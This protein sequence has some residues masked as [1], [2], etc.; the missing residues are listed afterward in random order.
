[1]QQPARGWPAVLTVG[2][3]LSLMASPAH[4]DGW[5]GLLRVMAAA[6][7]A[8][9]AL[10]A[11]ALGVVIEAEAY[12]RL[13]R[14]AVGHPWRSALVANAAGLPLMAAMLSLALLFAWTA[15]FGDES[16]LAYGLLGLAALAGA[17]AIKVGAV[18]LANRQRTPPEPLWPV[19]LGFALL[20]AVVAVGVEAVVWEVVA[21]F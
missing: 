21:S 14:R 18:C 4:A 19:V 8:V 1:M 9:S 17:L 6:L 11:G 5:E 2:A 7:G 20:T 15:P 10:I 16:S 13:L 12:R 3:C